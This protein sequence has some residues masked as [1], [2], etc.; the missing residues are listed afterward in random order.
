MMLLGQPTHSRVR[1]LQYSSGRKALQIFT[2][3][4]EP[5][6]HLLDLLQK[7]L[8]LLFLTQ[9]DR[10]PQASQILSWSVAP[11]RAIVKGLSVLLPCMVRRVRSRLTSDQEASL[12]WERIPMQSIHIKIL[13]YILQLHLYRLHLLHEITM[14]HLVYHQ[15]YI[16]WVRSEIRIPIIINIPRALSVWKAADL[17]VRNDYAL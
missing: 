5:H 13:S 15:S 10:V 9:T 8:Y 7:V 11:F 14:T 4:L 12:K 17:Y 16:D 2:R 1:T 3:R 6:R